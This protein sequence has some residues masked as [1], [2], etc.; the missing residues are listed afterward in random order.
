MSSNTRQSF[1]GRGWHFPPRFSRHGADVWTVAEEEDIQQSLR[2]L[3]STEQGERVMREDF[4]CD[5]R[6]LLFEEMTRSLVTDLTGMVTDAVLYYEP[7]IDLERVEVDTGDEV[8]GTLWIRIA[9]TVRSTNSRF[10][11]VFPFYLNEATAAGP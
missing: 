9:Y 6:R 5:L 8:S 10:N 2:I 7:R 3:L 1:L 4:G 11:L